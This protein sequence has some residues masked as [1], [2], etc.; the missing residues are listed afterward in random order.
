MRIEVPSRI[1]EDH[2]KLSAVLV[3]IKNQCKLPSLIEPYPLYMAD[4]IVKNI[5]QAV[6]SYR[7]I[8]TRRIVE[9]KKV[10]PDYVFFMMQS[11]RTES[12]K[13]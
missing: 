11:Y 7:Q 6:P 1:I 4:R 2:E 5:G 10:N 9:E 8:V 12:D 3:T 13:F